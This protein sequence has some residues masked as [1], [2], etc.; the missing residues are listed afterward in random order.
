MRQ[1]RKNYFINKDFQTKFILKFCVL[2]CVACALMGGLVYVLSARTITTSFENLR[3]V[4]KSTADF[5]LPALALSSLAAVIIASLACMFVVLFISHRIAGPLYRLEKSIGEIAS[6]DL[7]VKTN[8]R[9][10][11]EIKR[12]AECLNSMVERLR[13]AVE[14]SKQAAGELETSIGAIRGRLNQ[15]GLPQSEIDKLIG[16]CEAKLKELDQVLSFFKVK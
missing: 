16:A 5:I 11:D 8:L 1:K 15:C 13:Q 4:S 14:A 12:L 2:I 7:T 10:D 9:K 3:L 6:C